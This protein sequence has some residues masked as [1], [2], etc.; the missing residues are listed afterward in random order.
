MEQG[1]GIALMG[2]VY[3]PKSVP[4]LFSI[5]E[6]TR[7]DELV[8]LMLLVGGKGGHIAWAEYG[9]RLFGVPFAMENGN[10]VPFIRAPMDLHAM[11][12]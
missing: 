4:E 12:S 10:P 5:L 8:D 6:T 11:W 7:D 1:G 2:W 3:W 9:R